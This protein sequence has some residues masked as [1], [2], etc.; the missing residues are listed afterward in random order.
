MTTVTVRAISL[1]PG[2]AGFVRGYSQERSIYSPQLQIPVLFEFN[3]VRIGR[4]AATLPLSQRH[5]EVFEARGA[6]EQ[7]SATH[8]VSFF[9]IRSAGELVGSYSKRCKQDE[10]KPREGDDGFADRPR[11]HGFRDA[12]VQILLD[13]PESAV[14]YV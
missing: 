9:E 5:W 14:I 13:Q 2:L 6:F 12:Q 11:L 10:P 1:Q 7:S 3:G 4:G 8:P